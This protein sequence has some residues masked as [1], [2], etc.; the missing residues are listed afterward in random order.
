MN[1]MSPENFSRQGHA[2]LKSRDF[3]NA[4]ALFRKA[5]ELDK[6]RNKRRPDMRYLSY[7][8]L[9]LAH[10]G[11][12]HKVAIE[13][14]GS[15]ASKQ[16]NDPLLFLNLGRVYRLAGKRIQAIRAFES[17]LALAPDNQMLGRELALLDRRSRPVL[18]VLHRDHPLNRMLGKMR[19]NLRNR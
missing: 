4:A 18:P 1:S 13:A 3:R 14:C 7:Y 8:G 17:G 16:R 6:E 19:S 2:A 15:A 9:S 10:A 11:L 5:L 12:S